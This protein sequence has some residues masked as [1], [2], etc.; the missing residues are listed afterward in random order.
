MAGPAPSTRQGRLLRDSAPPVSRPAGSDAG[1]LA[2]RPPDRVSERPL[3]RAAVSDGLHFRG[4]RGTVL[5]CFESGSPRRREAEVC[6]VSRGTSH[7]LLSWNAIFYFC[8]PPFKK[9]LGAL[10]LQM[11]GIDDPQAGWLQQSCE[12]TEI[13]ERGVSVH[14][15]LGTRVV[16]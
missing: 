7:Q 4:C 5:A 13:F 11:A 2:P 15:L 16:L 9:G 1:R 3:P 14:R 6:A 12:A 10:N 8:F